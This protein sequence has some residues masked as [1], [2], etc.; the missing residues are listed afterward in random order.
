[1]SN[2]V[3]SL[4]S[5]NTIF[6]AYQFKPLLK[7]L[8]SDNRRLLIADEVGLGKTIEAGHI[9]LELMSRKELNNAIVVCPKSLQNKWQ[10]ELKEK[11]NLHFKIYETAKDF[12]NDIKEFGG[13]VK[14]IVNY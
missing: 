6:K 1:S 14:A 10:T 9:M 7:F 13:S 12:I 11:F 5:S 4:K 2:T 3:S 8:N